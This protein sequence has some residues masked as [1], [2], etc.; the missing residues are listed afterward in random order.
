MYEEGVKPPP[1]PAAPEPPA[2][3]ESPP[4]MAVAILPPGS[5][6]G[7]GEFLTRGNVVLLALY[8]G[9]FGGMWLLGRQAGGP[10]KALAQQRNMHAK[11]ESALSLL[12]ATP[13]GGAASTAKGIVSEFYM[14][15]KQRQLEAEL[16]P[17]NP[18]V[19]Q[20]TNV[21]AK[22]VEPEKPKL[23]AAPDEDEKY[24]MAAIKSLRLQSVLM[25]KQTVAVI[26]NNMLTEGQK[27]G[28]WTVSRIGAREVELTWKEKTHLLKMP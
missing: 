1:I 26:S 28:P 23:E 19:F 4:A 12:E 7:R 25:G 9:G 24:A 2:L 21:E 3:A 27:V 14:A 16:L 5:G 10:N 11:V 8:V 15:A 18:F 22:P 20:P 6:R 17:K 13:S